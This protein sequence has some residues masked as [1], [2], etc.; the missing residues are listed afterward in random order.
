[1]IKASTKEKIN[2]IAKKMRESIGFHALFAAG[3]I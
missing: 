2:S 3:S 1:M